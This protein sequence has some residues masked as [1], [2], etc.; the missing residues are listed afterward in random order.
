MNTIAIL[1]P[2]FL[3]WLGY[4]DLIKRVDGFVY[5]DDVQYIS[6]EWKN[7]NRIRKTPK[8]NETSW[9]SVP[10]EEKRQVKK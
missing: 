5:L 7:R 1:Q 6:R 2:H 10:V 8:S 9:L 4:F 3:P